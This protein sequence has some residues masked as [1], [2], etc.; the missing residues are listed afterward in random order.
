MAI[1]PYNTGKVKIGLR[2][3][4]SNRVQQD[5]EADRLQSALA[6]PVGQRRAT[7]RWFSKIAVCLILIAMAWVIWPFG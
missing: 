1:T 7:R 5:W 3:D 2:Y 6:P 4:P